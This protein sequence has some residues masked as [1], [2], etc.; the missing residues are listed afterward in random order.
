VAP[1]PPWRA[2]KRSV[3]SVRT[4]DQVE[5]MLLPPLDRCPRRLLRARRHRPDARAAQSGE[6]QRRPSRG[7]D[8]RLGAHAVV[9]GLARHS[10]R[11]YR[12]HQAHR[13]DRPAAHAVTARHPHA[14]RG[15]ACCPAVRHQLPGWHLLPTVGAAVV[16][17]GVAEAPVGRDELRDFSRDLLSAAMKGWR[18]ILPTYC[19][20]DAPPRLTAAAH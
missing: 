13:R 7:A 15:R 3:G 6:R 16:V 10:A 12:G 9:D 14:G 17:A 19:R 11:A 2:T 8:R 1:Y 20:R 4:F 18:V 5:A